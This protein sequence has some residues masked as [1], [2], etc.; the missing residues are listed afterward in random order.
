MVRER[1]SMPRSRGESAAI[2]AKLHR[3]ARH[4]SSPFS[5][6]DEMPSEPIRLVSRNTM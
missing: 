2:D 1:L 3:H 4:S 5:R 6:F